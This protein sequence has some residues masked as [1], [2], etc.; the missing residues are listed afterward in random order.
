M[1]KRNALLYTAIFLELQKLCPNLKSNIK[2]AMLDFERAVV[3]GLR[4]T[5]INTEIHICWFH[6]K[7]V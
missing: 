5:F 3:K 7:K 1:T 4:D 6:T 2:H